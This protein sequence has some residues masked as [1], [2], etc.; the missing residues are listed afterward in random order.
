MHSIR[1]IIMI[2]DHVIYDRHFRIYSIAFKIHTYKYPT[3]RLWLKELV[4]ITRAN[5]ISFVLKGNKYSM[6]RYH[7][8]VISDVRSIRDGFAIV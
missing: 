2:Y 8:D 4:F 1:K 3:H 7:R 5:C 6:L